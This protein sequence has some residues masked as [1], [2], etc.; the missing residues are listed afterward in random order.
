MTF[1]KFH[2]RVVIKAQLVAM[3]PIFVGAREDSFKPGTVKGSCVKDAYGRPYI[4]G[5][6]LKGSLRAFLS[7]LPDELINGNGNDKSVNSAIEG[8]LAKSKVEEKFGKKEDREKA[9]I[10]AKARN[11]EAYSAKED[12]EILAELIVA[13]STIVERLFGSKVMAGKVKIAD[14]TLVDDATST[15]VRN[16]VAIDR[17]TRTARDSALFD[18]E[19][20]PTGTLFHFNVSAENLKPDEAELFGKL[21]EY[22]ADGNITIGGRIRAGLGAV[23]LVDV[24][25]TTYKTGDSGFPTKETK[26]CGNHE[27]VEVIKNVCKAD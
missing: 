17:D 12:G 5:S 22:F 14:A 6:S 11:Q 10:E 21:M 9:V 19:V 4:P 26:N 25:V 23:G 13:D 18:T 24:R 20:V 7:S 27:I 16:G 8:K 15:E 3:T 2:N 1:E